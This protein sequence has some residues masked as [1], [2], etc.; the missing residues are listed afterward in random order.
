MAVKLCGIFKFKKSDNTDEH[1]K[2]KRK[3]SP[4]ISFPIGK[5]S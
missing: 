3:K 4:M 1:K 5:Y 2:R